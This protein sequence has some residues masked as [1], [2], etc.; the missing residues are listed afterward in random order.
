MKRFLISLLVGILFSGVTFGKGNNFEEKQAVME[1]VTYENQGL[2]LKA[3]LNKNMVDLRIENNTPELIS[4]IWSKSYYRGL[5]G[6]ETRVY[7]YNQIKLGPYDKLIN[8]GIR[9][10]DYREVKLVPFQNLEF[11]S[12]VIGTNSFSHRFKY[13][14]LDRSSSEYKEKNRE[15]GEIV[16]YIEQGVKKSKIA[17]EIILK[18]QE[19][20]EKVKIV[21][22]ETRSLGNGKNSFEKL[23]KQQ[24][25]NNDLELVKKSLEDELAQKERELKLLAEIE[26]LKKQ[27]EE[28]NKMLN[29]KK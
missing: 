22:I 11:E 1:Q 2:L 12:P 9:P 13:E 27:I 14:I 8:T 6:K 18:L 5:D 17:Y 26:V 3:D 25:R 15:Y 10:G 28:K 21:E 7:D 20:T 23:E 29:I 16:L 19:E 4:V 24:N